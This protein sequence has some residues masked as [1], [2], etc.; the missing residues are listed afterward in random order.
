MLL[1]FYLFLFLRI[2]RNYNKIIKKNELHQ[3][4]KLKSDLAN[5]QIDKIKTKYSNEFEISVR[6]Y[7]FQKLLGQFFLKQLFFFFNSK[8]I[9]F[10]IPREWNSIFEKNSF[11]VS[12]FSNLLFKIFLL[13]K[14]FNGISFI[15]QVFKEYF[16]KDKNSHKFSSDDIIIHNLPLRHLNFLSSNS[17]NVDIK[18][19]LNK[20]FPNHNFF[21]INENSRKINKNNINCLNYYYSNLIPDLKIFNFLFS[22]FKIIFKSFFYLISNN[23]SKVLMTEEI[24]KKVL[25]ESIK[26]NKKNFPKKN[27]F[28]YTSNI[29]RPLWTYE[30]E[31]HSDIDLLM[32]SEL[33]DLELIS[34]NLSKNYNFRGYNLI[35]WKEIYVWTKENYYDFKKK[36]PDSNI[37][38]SD[39]ISIVDKKIDLNFSNRIISLFSYNMDKGHYGISQT[40]DYLSN[41]Q[42]KDNKFFEDIIL[43]SEKY[44]FNILIKNKSKHKKH[45]TKKNMFYMKKVSSKKNIQIIDSEVSPHRIIQN[46]D[47]VISLPLTSTF[48]IGKYYSKPSI[49]Y[50]PINLLKKQGDSNLIKSL[51]DLEQWFKNLDLKLKFK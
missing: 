9:L 27:I 33:S 20:K 39:P 31:K 1:R 37:Y 35:T 30:L 19:W 15:F 12:L 29:Y 17:E 23:W 8:K 28:F 14:I 18:F 4:R 41:T 38:I 6:Q 45:V 44:N 3:I 26:V 2:Q 36:L 34:D 49:Y 24:I 50:D 32:T 43:L 10:P 25:I 21:F 42:N 51:P 47:A 46:S 22:S 16:N 11:K 5:H 40:I 13:S 48:I 7:L